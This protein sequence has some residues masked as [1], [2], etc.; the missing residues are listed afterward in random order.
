VPSLLLLSSILAVS[1]K[2]QLLLRFLLFS[3]P[4]AVGLQVN[5]RV[6][7]FLF[8]AR[9]RRKIFHVNA[10]LQRS[11]KTSTGSGQAKHQQTTDRHATSTRLIKDFCYH[12]S[13]LLSL[14]PVL[15]SLI[16]F[17]KDFFTK[18]EIK[19]MES[20]QKLNEIIIPFPL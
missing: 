3:S 17:V 6:S 2:S 12:C 5:A 13:F 11:C 10:I 7:A 8:K 16:Q 14:L 15:M 20:L 1:L 9:R 19:Y 4:F 18:S